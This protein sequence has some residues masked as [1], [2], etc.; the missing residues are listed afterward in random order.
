MRS[1]HACLAS[2]LFLGV[3]SLAR[4]SCTASS[5]TLCMNDG[6]F[7]ASV[8]WKDFKARTGVGTA[9]P[10][11]ADTGYFWF[12]SPANIELVIKV[13]DARGV[14]GKYWVFFGAVLVV[15]LVGF[16]DLGIPELDGFVA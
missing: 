14:N 6:R 15:L 2:L 7:S 3:A 5:T 1:R 4:A 13:L 9:I 8:A 11:T 16:F 10:I 12:F